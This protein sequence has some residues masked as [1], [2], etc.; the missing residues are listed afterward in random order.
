MPK[1]PAQ[2]NNWHKQA[3]GLP[4]DFL[5]EEGRQSLARPSPAQKNASTNVKL[6]ESF[7]KKSMALD[8]HWSNPKSQSSKQPPIA[9]P[10]AGSVRLTLG[11]TE[12]PNGF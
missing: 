11:S 5:L 8:P 6:L 9:V 2:I 10:R 3:Q 12:V 1:P 4:H 7:L